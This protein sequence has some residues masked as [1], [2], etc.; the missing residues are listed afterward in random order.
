MKLEHLS[1]AQDLYERRKRLLEDIRDIRDGETYLVEVTGTSFN[2]SHTETR[3]VFLAGVRYIDACL[4]GLGVEVN[5][6]E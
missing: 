2:L 1:R 5:D 4:R 6:A 3:A